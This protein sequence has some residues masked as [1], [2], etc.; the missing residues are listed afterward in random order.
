[1]CAPVP[2][3][4]ILSSRVSCAC[5]LPCPGCYLN[6]VVNLVSSSYPRSARLT[7][8]AVVVY[9][10]SSIASADAASWLENRYLAFDTAM[11]TVAGVVADEEVYSKSWRQPP[12]KE[13]LDLPHSVGLSAI[14]RVGGSYYFVADTSYTLNGELITPRDVIL[15]TATGVSSVFLRGR[16][17]G[18]A[19]SVKIVA[20][21]FDGSA[22]LF[23]TDSTSSIGSVLASPADIIRWDGST[24]SIAYSA[25]RLGISKGV[26]VSALERLSNGRLLLSVNS[27]SRFEGFVATPGDVLEFNPADNRMELNRTAA[28][29]A[30]VCNPC[31]ISALAADGPADALLRSGFENFEE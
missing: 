25:G 22:I 1:M 6:G 29:L 5:M 27:S 21:A 19:D 13:S 4:Y 12:R 9:L 31:A 17:I 24:V 8:R 30:S 16:D 3:V 2:L 15:R 14:S 18:L 20:L 11:E 26:G 23:S 28:Q 7:R 10:I